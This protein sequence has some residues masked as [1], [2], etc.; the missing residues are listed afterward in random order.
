MSMLMLLMSLIIIPVLSKNFILWLLV[1]LV[2]FS[3]VMLILGLMLKLYSYGFI[4][5]LF[6]MSFGVD[7]L[8]ILLILLSSWIV[9]L[10]LLSS[11][12]LLKFKGLDY[13]GL[14]M[15]LLMM[16]FVVFLTSNM[17]VF[18]L[19]FESI[20]LP[21]FI[22]IMGWG[23]QP[24]R[25][26]AS[27]YFLF[28][29]VFASLPLLLMLF[30]VMNQG[31]S[32]NWFYYCYYNFFSVNMNWVLMVMFFFFT[33]SF[34]V[35]VPLYF[36]HL[37]LPK[38]HVE[39][40]VSGSMILAGVLLKLGGYGLYRFYYLLSEFFIKINLYYIVFILFG[41]VLSSLV[42]LFQ[43][44]LKS[45]IAYSSVAHMGLMISGVMNLSLVSFNGGLIMMI[46]HGLC[47]SGLFCLANM[48]YERLGSRSMMLSKGLLNIFP[49]L[50]IWM[51]LLIICNI[52]AP[53]SMNLFGEVSLF[54]SLLHY[55]KMSLAILF[56]FSFFCSCYSIY[57]Y[58]NTQHGKMNLIY[59]FSFISVRELNL[60][61]LHWVPLNFFVFK[62]DLFYF[63]Y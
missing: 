30:F 31:K 58:Y 55:S 6:F 17:F 14:L 27:I 2:K 34:M 18:Y 51:F 36:F 24:E 22:L 57:L 38:A 45:L 63:C 33:F 37:W 1:L 10:M 42:C 39:A 32:L 47:S 20:L 28:Y 4:F 40:P 7:S 59:P 41:S 26:Q 62:V 50:N 9:F 12:N 53:P 52:S 23:Y 3:L 16:L 35:K 21:T 61:M 19:F 13:V 46:G 5:K 60:L 43:V 15:V 8:S 44:D 49:S 48:I 11:V 25:L 29:T 54:M 56:I